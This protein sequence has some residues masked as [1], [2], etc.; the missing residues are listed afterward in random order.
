[1]DDATTNFIV[2]ISDDYMFCHVFEDVETCKELLERVLGI[3]IEEISPPTYQKEIR[4]GINERGI[5]LDIYVR[6]AEGNSYD[7]EMQTYQLSYLGKRVRYYHSEMDGEMLKQGETYDK[8]RKNIVIF[9]YCAGDPFG[10]NR[11]VYTFVNT[12]VEDKSIELGD[13]VLT[14]ILWPGGSYEG[15]D[16][17]L[18]NVLNYINTGETNDDFTA[19]I[20]DKTAELSNDRGWRSGYMTYQQRMYEEQMRGF[21]RGKAE[22]IA[23]GIAEGK[24]AGIVEGKAKA[25]FELV[26][27]GDMR[28]EVAAEKLNLPIDEFEK[29]MTDAGYKIPVC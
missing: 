16:G 24:A 13:D 21:E 29:Q 14:I 25:F 2:P 22:G 1:M 9:F 15:I 6:D 28:T 19:A 12:C 11:S 20:A 23:E 10:K 8:L 5:R 26:Q 18:A 7:I 17:K 4:G 3:E 27:D